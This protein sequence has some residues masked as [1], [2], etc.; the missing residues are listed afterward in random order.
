M[1]RTGRRGIERVREGERGG[2]EGKGTDGLRRSG[3]SNTS[4]ASFF[5]G[6]LDELGEVNGDV[7]RVGCEEE[8][9]E[10]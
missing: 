7:E 8:G 1:Q 3:E 2:G 4:C 9:F 5:G 10:S 6:T